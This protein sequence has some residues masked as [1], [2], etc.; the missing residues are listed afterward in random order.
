MQADLDHCLDLIG[1]AEA[2]YV[3]HPRDPGG[4]TNHGITLKT[5]AAWR[6][7]P[8]TIADVQALTEAEA[9]QIM[10]AQY[11]SLVRFDVLPPGL[12]YAVLDTS[13]NSGPDRAVKLLQAALGMTGQD[14]DGVFGVHTKSVLD[15]A[16]DVDGV[17]TTYCAARLA[18]MQRLRTWGTFGHGWS[19]RVQRVQSEAMMMAHGFAPPTRQR[20]EDP[21]GRAK[22]QGPT[23]VLSVPSG[24]A[25]VATVGTVAATAV[26]AAGQASGVLQPYADIMLV[27]DGLLGLAVVSAVATLV[28]ALTRTRAGATT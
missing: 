15:G 21:L 6:G 13:V 28:V 18:F 3:N 11:A 1:T 26:T 16:P 7:K 19:A 2:G 27:R 12:D 22:A 23:K 17:I 8:V 5:L 10:D 4:P 24:Q 9:R 14:V 20:V 25:A